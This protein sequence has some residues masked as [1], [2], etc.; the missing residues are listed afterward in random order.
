MMTEVDFCEGPSV[1][2]RRLT[3]RM[4]GAKAA[5]LAPV[6]AALLICLPIGESPDEG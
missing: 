6:L 2:H 5:S 3:R 4:N 1:T